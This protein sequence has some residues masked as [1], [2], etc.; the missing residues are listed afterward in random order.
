MP[1]RN[2]Q[3]T[4]SKS[5]LLI[6]ALAILGRGMRNLLGSYDIKSS[7]P[8]KSSSEVHNSHL[9]RHMTVLFWSTQWV[10]NPHS[11]LENHNNGYM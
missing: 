5:K 9:K 6:K 4:L 10:F 3:K 8:T 1:H 2:H 11:D 7:P